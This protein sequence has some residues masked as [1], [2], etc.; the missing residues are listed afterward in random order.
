MRL[1][2]KRNLSRRSMQE[3]NNNKALAM[4]SSNRALAMTS[5]S[6]K[7]VTMMS[8]SRSTLKMMKSRSPTTLLRMT[9][10]FL[11]RKRSRVKS[12]T[13]TSQLRNLL[14]RLGISKDQEYKVKR[15]L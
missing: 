11:T 4:V 2:S 6:N 15:I 8:S 13:V 10:T 7:A 3:S 5:S 12:L 9:S 1:S 14:F